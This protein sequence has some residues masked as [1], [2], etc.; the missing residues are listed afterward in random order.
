MFVERHWKVE[1]LDIFGLGK[2]DLKILRDIEK[3]NKFI[4]INKFTLST[5]EAL[6]DTDVVILT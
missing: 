4:N 5:K 2:H 6:N 1:S 3:I